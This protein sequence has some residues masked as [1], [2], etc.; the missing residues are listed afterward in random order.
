MVYRGKLSGGCESCR[1]AKKRCGLEQ[2]SCSR[3]VKLKKVCSGCRDTTQLT[4]HDESESVRLKVERQKCKRVD[5]PQQAKTPSQALAPTVTVCHVGLLPNGMPMTASSIKDSSSGSDFTPDVEMIEEEYQ[6]PPAGSSESVP[7][8]LGAGMTSL[9]LGLPVGMKPQPDDVATNYFFEQFTSSGH[10]EFIRTFARHSKLDPGLDLA[11][12]AC[13]MA[14]LTN[15]ESV[16]RGK[17]YARLMYADALSLV[18][19]ALRDGEK[20]VMDETLIAVLMLG[21][22]EN[23]TSDSQRSIQSWQT[24]VNGAA[25]LLELRGKEQFKTQVG[26]VLFR[27]TR[28]QVLMQRIWNNQEA[29]EFL[30]EY[31]AELE[32]QTPEEFATVSK[33]WDKISALCF[34][35]AKLRAQITHANDF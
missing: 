21:W 11:I 25:K 9:G 33:T 7:D 15:V 31:Q 22:Y 34:P 24:H 30:K 32:A 27:E 14:A 35:F 17:D 16:A 6:E 23:I 19:Q 13:G 5:W 18:N 28:T 3:C 4:I 26:R 20:S 29:P 10:W 12:R 8:E 2:P 1:K